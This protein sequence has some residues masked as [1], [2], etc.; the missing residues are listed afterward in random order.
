[1][2]DVFESAVLTDSADLVVDQAGMVG[3]GASEARVQGLALVLTKISNLVSVAAA[4]ANPVI[5]S[6]HFEAVTLS[7][8]LGC[9]HREQHL[10]LHVSHL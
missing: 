8:C 2:A 3:V 4:A 7:S 1:M 5:L 9:A 10:R 6:V